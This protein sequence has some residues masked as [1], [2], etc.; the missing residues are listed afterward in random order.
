MMLN[1]LLRLCLGALFFVAG[2]AKVPSAQM[3]AASLLS[4]GILPE[5]TIGLVAAGLPWLEVYI[6]LSLILQKD[7]RCAALLALVTSSCFVLYV[8]FVLKYHPHSTCGCLGKL[9][10]LPF[11]G[12]HLFVNIVILS[13]S[14]QLFSRSK[15]AQS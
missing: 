12:T 8:G 13:A 5:P 9:A 14:W 6:G 3:F 2:L 10:Q 4:Q 15:P 1:T 7:M 11:S